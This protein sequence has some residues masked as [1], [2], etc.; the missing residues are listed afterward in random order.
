MQNRNDNECLK[1]SLR[2]ALFPALKNSHRTTSYPT[3]DGIN[4]E[5]IDFPTPIKQIDKLEAQNENL[6]INVFGWSDRVIVYRVS[7]KTKKVNRINLMLIESRGKQHYTYGKRINALLYNQTRHIES[8][9]YCLMCLIGFLK[10][11]ILAEREK[12]CEGIESKPTRTEMPNES[13]KDL[14]SK[15][16][17]KQ[18]KVPYVIYAEFESLIQKTEGPEQ[19][20]EKQESFTENKSKHMACGYA[21]NVVRSDGK[22]MSAKY[23]RG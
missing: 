15:N 3:N 1:W 19:K 10:R 23:R 2:A 13:D 5:G 22:V 18:Q 9:H 11:E 7:K 6:A 4:Y 8:K 16:Y 12:H 14:Y 21:Y 20:R 17:K